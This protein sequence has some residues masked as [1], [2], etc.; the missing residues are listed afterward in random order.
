MK[1][2]NVVKSQTEFTHEGAK[3]HKQ[4]AF[5]ELK[6]SV[7]AN[8]LWEQNGYENGEDIATRIKNLV[9]KVK[10]EYVSA[11]A[12]AARNEFKL[13]HIPLFLIRE[14]ARHDSHK[15][16]IVDTMEKVINRADEMPELLAILWKDG[17]CP[18]PNS[19]KKGLAKVF[20][21][22]NSYQLQKYNRDTEIK[23]RDVLF[24]SHPKP[25]DKA[26]EKVWKQLAD[27]ELPTPDTWETELSQ[28]T[29]K[30][31]SW[32]RL[33][34]EDK[35]GA[36]ALLRNLRNCQE[37][38]VDEN[39]IRKSLQNCNPEM[40]LPFR[41][42]SAAKFAPIFE[43]EL[44]ALMFKCLAEKPRLKGRTALV[45]DVSGSMTMHKISAKSDLDRLEAATG[46]AILTREV[47]EKVDIYTF[48]KQTVQ[49]PARRG[50]ALKDTIRQSQPNKDTFL[51]PAI[52]LVN[53]KNYDRIIVLS[54]EQVADNIPAP[55][56]NYSY[57]INVSSNK[58]GVGYGKF[59]VCLDGWSEAIIDY[60]LALESQ[61]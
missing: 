45:V 10:P 19:I 25:N 15:P 51:A 36:L 3:V 34:K 4:T 52:E 50:F 61:E 42:L 22:F 47:C 7:L 43:P 58:N 1:L 28:S 18:I 5:N 48:S 49:I 41:F 24:L 44:E 23:L 21:K 33:L 60:I 20:P 11:L 29:D 26:Q 9:P 13:R 17:K 55:K 53:S 39:L 59:K 32:T 46:L 2:N 35:L 37:A 54:D 12:I 56:A 30:H 8:L 16:F 6:R 38:K 40:V 31:A 14:M 27:N 57:M